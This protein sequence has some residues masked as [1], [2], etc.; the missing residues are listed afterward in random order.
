MGLSKI[1]IFLM[2]SGL[3]F[4]MVRNVNG[5]GVRVIV[6]LY[7]SILGEIVG[8]SAHPYEVS[9]L[10]IYLVVLFIWSTFLTGW[11]DTPFSWL[12]GKPPIIITWMMPTT[13]MAGFVSTV[14]SAGY[15][16]ELSVWIPDENQDKSVTHPCAIICKKSEVNSQ[17]SGEFTS[18]G[19]K[20]CWYE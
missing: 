8:P 5:W 7:D 20:I 4:L 18:K 2:L 12:L 1:L 19:S 6:E 16:V 17:R 15:H 10:M 14:L 3:G 11:Y 13:V 9:E